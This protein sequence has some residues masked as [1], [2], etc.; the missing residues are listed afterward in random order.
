MVNVRSQKK[1]V[2]TPPKPAEETIYIG[3]Y[4]SSLQLIT[5]RTRIIDE[6][7]DQAKVETVE[8]GVL[9]HH[10][11]QVSEL[12]MVFEAI[13]RELIP[14]RHEG[15]PLLEAMFR[16]GPQETESYSDADDAVDIR[17]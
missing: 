9:Q 3:A 5:S 14:M 13:I 2:T 16:Q 7:I 8:S 17:N 15:K 4:N 10:L 6:S 12:Q 1:F 11:K